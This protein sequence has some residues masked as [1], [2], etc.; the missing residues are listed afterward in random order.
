MKARHEGVL[1]SYRSMSFD[2]CFLRPDATVNPQDKGR[3]A[4]KVDDELFLARKQ[5]TFSQAINDM[6]CSLRN[7]SYIQVE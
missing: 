1:Y 6:G 5:Y 2:I 4:H 3:S 7:V